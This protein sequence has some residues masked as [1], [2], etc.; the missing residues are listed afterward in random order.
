MEIGLKGLTRDGLGS[1]GIGTTWPFRHT[2]GKA[3]GETNINDVG[4]SG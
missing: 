2:N 3:C 4:N 1:F